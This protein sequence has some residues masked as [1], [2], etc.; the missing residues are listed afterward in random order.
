MTLRAVLLAIAGITVISG[1][2]QVID[3]AFVLTMVGAATGSAVQH[4]FG[5]VGMFMVLFGGMLLHA[6]LAGDSSP[7]PVL[8][9]GL[10]KFGAAAAV[11]LGVARAVFS[12]AALAVAGFD[13]LSGVLI[14]L[15]WRTMP[16]AVNTRITNGAQ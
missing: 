1:A 13:F 12:D 15:Y 8:W 3:P 7:L 9:A 2:V 11:G 4:F 10:Q 6:L 5:I 14:F 16:R